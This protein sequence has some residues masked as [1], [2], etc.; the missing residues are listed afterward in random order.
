MI[1]KILYFL[2]SYFFKKD[3]TIYTI[4]CTIRFYSR[5]VRKRVLSKP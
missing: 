3:T 2:F 1:L 4:V 5:F